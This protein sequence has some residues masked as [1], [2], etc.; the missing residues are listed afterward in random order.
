MKLPSS[1]IFVTFIFLLKGFDV[2]ADRRINSSQWYT[3]H[4]LF[5][6]RKINEK[7]HAYKQQT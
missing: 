2:R 4:C 3:V 1:H 7:L 5:I 6:R